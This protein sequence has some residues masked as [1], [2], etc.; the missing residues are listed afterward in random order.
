LAILALLP[1]EEAHHVPISVT[2]SLMKYRAR[3]IGHY[4]INQKPLSR[5]QRY[6]N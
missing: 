4:E 3:Y 5:R 2:F 1:N 6:W